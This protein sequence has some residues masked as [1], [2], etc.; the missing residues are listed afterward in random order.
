MTW[1]KHARPA[2]GGLSVLAVWCGGYHFR[3]HWQLGAAL[4]ALG[5]GLL[6]IWITMEGEE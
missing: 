1:R 5:I 2:I 6:E 4:T 3:P